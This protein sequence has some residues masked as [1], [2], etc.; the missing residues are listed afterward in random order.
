MKAVQI[1]ACILALVL[2]LPFGLL[3][4]AGYL[5]GFVFEA[6]YGGARKGQEAF[7]KVITYASK[8]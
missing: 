2:A 8:S 7:K 4:I 6:I 1:F 5:V 3:I